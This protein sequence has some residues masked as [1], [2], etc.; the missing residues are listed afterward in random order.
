MNNHK[1]VFEQLPDGAHE[2]PLVGP[3][4]EKIGEAAVTIKDGVWTANLKINAET[5][6]N[7]GMATSL[8]HTAFNNDEKL[9][10]HA[11]PRTD[12]EWVEVSGTWRVKPNVSKKE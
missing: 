10:V 5:A 12:A 4:G 6:K 8:V 2:V 3:S 7:L 11:Y 1:L 9:E